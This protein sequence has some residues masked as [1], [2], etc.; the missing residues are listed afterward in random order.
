MFLFEHLYYVV[1]IIM[2]YE[3]IFLKAGLQKYLTGKIMFVTINECYL[4]QSN[5]K[6]VEKI[7]KLIHEKI[8]QCI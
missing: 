7:I 5:N 8:I 2:T 3:M 4:L 1:K 6:I